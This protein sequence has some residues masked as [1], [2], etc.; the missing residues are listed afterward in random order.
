MRPILNAREGFAS[1]VDGFGTVLS[2]TMDDAAC[3]GVRDF[4]VYLPEVGLAKGSAVFTFSIWGL[5]L[6]TSK[7]QSLQYLYSPVW[8]LCASSVVLLEDSAGNPVCLKV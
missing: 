5:A 2:V 1:R 3:Y 8:S 6:D 7:H 4:Q